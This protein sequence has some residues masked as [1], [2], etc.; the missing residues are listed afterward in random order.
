L[1][2]LLLAG[3]AGGAEGLDALAAEV[4]ALARAVEARRLGG[5]AGCS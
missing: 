4:E 1:E 3:R 5:R 2:L